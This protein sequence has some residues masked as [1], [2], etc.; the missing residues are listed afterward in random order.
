MDLPAGYCMT[1]TGPARM[2]PAGANPAATTA[3]HFI[4]G[5]VTAATQFCADLDIG[6]RNGHIDHG[7]PGRERRI[8]ILRAH[9]APGNCRT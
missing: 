1:R 8:D 3:G 9:P 6:D 5:T 7:N 4:K 2:K